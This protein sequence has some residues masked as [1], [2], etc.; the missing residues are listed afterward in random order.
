[1]AGE[2]AADG[3][4]DEPDHADGEATV[5][6]METE[7]EKEKM[8]MVIVTVTEGRNFAEKMLSS[9]LFQLRWFHSHKCTDSGLHIDSLCPLQL[10]HK[11]TI[12]VSGREGE[13]ALCRTQ[14]MR[15][16]SESESCS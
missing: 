11:E 5:A 10:N 3:I 4:E 1:M 12:A 14:R 13:D 9:T 7:T 8:K 2:D 15:M 16:A 6:R